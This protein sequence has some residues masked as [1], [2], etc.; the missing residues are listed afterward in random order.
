MTS[1]PTHSPAPDLLAALRL[2]LEA[3]N[4]AP[5][6]RVGRTDSYKIAVTVGTAIAKATA[7]SPA[8][9]PSEPAASDLPARFDAYEI[10]PCRRFREDGD[11]DRFY[12]E[13]CKPEEADVWTLYGHIPGEGGEAIGDFESCKLAEQVYARITGRSYGQKGGRP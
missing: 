10:G 2:A 12:Y 11:R 13:P 7:T 1:I 9:I 4:T 3:L 5:R 6:F 8:S